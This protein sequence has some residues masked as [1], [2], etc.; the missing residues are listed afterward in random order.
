[1]YVYIYWKYKL[2]L[3]TEMPT[4]FIYLYIH[5]LIYMQLC[6]YPQVVSQG[7]MAAIYRVAAAISSPFDVFFLANIF[8]EY[9]IAAF[10]LR[11][12]LSYAISS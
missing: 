6:I 12:D 5:I 3:P 4:K 11:L 9:Q 1:M 8:A 7:Q 2:S 10:K